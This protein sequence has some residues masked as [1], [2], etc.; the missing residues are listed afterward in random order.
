MFKNICRSFLRK[1]VNGEIDPSFV[2]THEM[3][4][5]D[6]PKGYSIF[7]EKRSLH[8]GGTEAIKSN[9]KS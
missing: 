7:K 1:I 9:D 4:L 2:I 5:E 8:Q 6:A 3:K